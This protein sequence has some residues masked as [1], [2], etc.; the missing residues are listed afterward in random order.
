MILHKAWLGLAFKFIINLWI[1]KARSKIVL[2]RTEKEWKEWMYVY[3]ISRRRT[4]EEEEEGSEAEWEKEKPGVGLNIRVDAGQLRTNTFILLWV[5]IILTINIFP[6]IIIS[7]LPPTRQEH[8]EDEYPG[9]PVHI[10][11][12]KLVEKSSSCCIITVLR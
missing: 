10:G 12:L 11:F 3:C 6:Y 2:K 9:P 5:E 1:N 4:G 7:N 8:R